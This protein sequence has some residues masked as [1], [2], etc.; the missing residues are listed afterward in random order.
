MLCKESF[1]L[2]KLTF[3][4]SS[5]CSDTNR[6]GLQQNHMLNVIW[7]YY[8]R[9]ET[10]TRGFNTVSSENT[11]Y[12][13]KKL[14]SELRFLFDCLQSFTHFNAKL[15]LYQLNTQTARSAEFK[16]TKNNRKLKKNMN[17]IFFQNAKQ[18]QENV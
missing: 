18:M 15:F 2:K 12:G 10:Q 8:K 3:S 6:S 1:L 4:S 9:C 14:P 17:E 7:A 11:Y 13:C 16:L 5:D